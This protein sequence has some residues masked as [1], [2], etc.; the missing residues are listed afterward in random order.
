MVF[1]LLVG[2]NPLCSCRSWQVRDQMMSQ[3]TGPLMPGNTSHQ[4]LADFHG[5]CRVS[6]A[7]ISVVVTIEASIPR[8]PITRI[9][10]SLI[11]MTQI[12]QIRFI[13]ILNIILAQHN[14]GQL[15]TSVMIIG[16]ILDHIHCSSDFVKRSDNMWVSRWH[17]FKSPE[18]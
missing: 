6:L 3:M 9:S 15:I 2:P 12:K 1:L 18:E 11:N 5:V 8:L 16:T 4:P 10:S 13:E 14:S 17:R 7:V